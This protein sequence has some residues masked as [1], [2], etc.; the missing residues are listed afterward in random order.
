MASAPANDDELGS[1][2]ETEHAEDDLE[3]TLSL[4]SSAARDALAVEMLPITIHRMLLLLF[5]FGL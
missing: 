4:S 1:D 3:S 2:S 5:W